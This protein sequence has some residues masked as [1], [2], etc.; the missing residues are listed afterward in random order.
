MTND[1]VTVDGTALTHDGADLVDTAAM[2]ELPELHVDLP[3]AMAQGRM[4]FLSLGMAR[5]YCGAPARSS[6]QEGATTF[7]ELTA[8]LVETIREAAA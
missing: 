1:R 3:A 2:R 8:M 7:E 6:A 5:A 4:D